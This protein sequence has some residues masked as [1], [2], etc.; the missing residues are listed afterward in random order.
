[1]K[2]NANG[3]DD[4]GVFK[5]KEQK[6]SYFDNHL[7]TYPKSLKNLGEVSDEDKLSIYFYAYN[8]GDK[9]YETL[10]DFA[11][12]PGKVRVAGSRGQT[13]TE[14]KEADATLINAAY[15]FINFDSK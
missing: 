11:Q 8:Q 5:I 15:Y 10:L 6:L 14:K 4:K 12:T 1:M 7:I 3:N 2:T 13:L 9:V